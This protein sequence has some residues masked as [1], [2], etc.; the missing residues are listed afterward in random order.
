M[1]LFSSHFFVTLNS[2]QS[3]RD[4][5]IDMTIKK[6]KKLK[7]VRNHILIGKPSSIAFKN[8]AIVRSS[9]EWI[10]VLSSICSLSIVFGKVFIILSINHTLGLGIVGTIWT[11]QHILGSFCI[12]KRIKLRIR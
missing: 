2:F 3:S 6:K 12:E 11:M 9:I 1:S 10:T 4:L 8:Q 5:S 7:I